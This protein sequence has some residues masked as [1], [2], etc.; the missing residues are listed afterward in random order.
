MQSPR[1]STNTVLRMDSVAVTQRNRVEFQ[2]QRPTNDEIK[3]VESL[4]ELF[5][6]HFLD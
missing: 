5:K 4:Q 6:I 3:V 2:Q 1:K